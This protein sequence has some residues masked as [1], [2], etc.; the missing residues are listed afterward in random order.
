MEPIIYFLILG[1][2]AII[3]AVVC[4]ILWSKN[5]ELQYKVDNAE[6]AEANALGE[7]SRIVLQ[8]EKLWNELQDCRRKR[9]EKGRYI[10][11]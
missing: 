7:V 6:L 5:K 1:F 2:I 8:N 4:S 9:D 3:L 10:K 11:K